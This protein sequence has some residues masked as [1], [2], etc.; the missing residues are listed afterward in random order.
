M[1][2]L[3]SRTPYRNLGSINRS[4]IFIKLECN[5][6]GNSFKSRGVINFLQ[7]IDKKDGLVTFTTGNHGIAVAAI[8]K[9]LGIKSIVLSTNKLSPY[10]K[11]LIE[12]YGATIELIDN[13]NLYKATE[14]AKKNRHR[15]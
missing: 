10:K 3:I 11:T 12:N 1:L 6:F 4:D 9:E 14:Y 2:N 8:A 13:H 15:E 5:Q 7:N